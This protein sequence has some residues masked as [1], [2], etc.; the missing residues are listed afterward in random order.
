MFNVTQLQRL[1][2]LY[3]TGAD[4]AALGLPG[5]GQPGSQLSTALVCEKNQMPR[6][7]YPD[8]YRIPEAS[9]WDEFIYLFI[10]L[11]CDEP[12]GPY[13]PPWV[14]QGR[15][16]DCGCEEGGF[17]SSG[18]C[19]HSQQGHISPLQTQGTQW[20]HCAEAAGNILCGS[21][22]PRKT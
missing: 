21:L 13:I 16:A 8:H 11:K 1:V 17:L 18:G 7:L 19:L 10:F 2:P 14:W 22:S 3:S 5:M 6:L 12:D 15:G 20:T 4:S 9:S